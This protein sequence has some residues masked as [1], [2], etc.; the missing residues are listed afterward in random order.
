MNRLHRGHWLWGRALALGSSTGTRV[1]N[2]F[3]LFSRQLAALE[4]FKNA[5]KH[6]VVE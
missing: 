6:S 1:S 3:Y 5:W 2:K 4:A